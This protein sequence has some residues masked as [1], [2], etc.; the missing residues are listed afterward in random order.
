MTVYADTPR[1]PRHGLL[2]GHMISDRS[3]AELHERAREAGLHP[4]S[5]D[6]DHY[7]WP[8]HARADLVAAGVVM[9]GNKELTRRLIAGGLRIPAARR[10]AARR[11]R[12]EAAARDLGL[13]RVPLD[14][15]TGPV[16]HVDPLPQRPVAFRLT[17]DEAGAAPRIEAQ[18]ADGRRAAERFLAAVDDASWTRTGALWTGQVVDAPES[19]RPS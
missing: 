15:I 16:G 3:L 8:E 9:V 2:W 1:W 7:D 17:R 13:D 18:D 14:L 6:L 10:A 19:G 4:R 11:E 12:T 5:F